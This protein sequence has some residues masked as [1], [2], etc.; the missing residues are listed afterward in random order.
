MTFFTLISILPEDFNCVIKVDCQ[1]LLNTFYEVLHNTTPSKTYRRPMYHLWALIYSTTGL[2]QSGFIFQYRKLKAIPRTSLMKGQTFL[3]KRASFLPPSLSRH[4]TYVTTFSVFLPSQ[5]TIL[6]LKGI[7]ENSSLSYSKHNSLN[8]S[9][10]F[11]S[12]I[13]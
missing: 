4:K 7:L 1:A 6:L 8:N 10:H 9:F 2:M 3:Q 13:L 12:S 11:H 5:K